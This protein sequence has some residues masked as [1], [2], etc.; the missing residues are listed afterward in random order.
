LDS[1][2]VTRWV[3]ALDRG[4][5][6]G[7]SDFAAGLIRLSPL[8]DRSEEIDRLH[9]V[10]SR[11]AEVHNQMPYNNASQPTAFGGG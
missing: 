10:V 11:Q 5:L 9:G 3:Q 8:N 6:A 2:R 1:K 4:A 7:A